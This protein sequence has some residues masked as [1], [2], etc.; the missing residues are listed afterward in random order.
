MCKH[1]WESE[2][3]R[4]HAETCACWKVAAVQWPRP[5]W[6]EEKNTVHNSLALTSLRLTL[7]PLPPT[8]NLSFKR[9]LTKKKLSILLKQGTV[10]CE[11]DILPED[12]GEIHRW[13]DHQTVHENL[14]LIR[15]SK[16][17]NCLIIK[18]SINWYSYNKQIDLFYK[19]IYIYI[20]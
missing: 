15:I 19:Y 18:Q 8:R 2:I 1:D 14:K 20:S 10:T 9:S 11:L 13:S 4:I 16:M 12:L 17:R 7:P 6:T 3:L 5:G